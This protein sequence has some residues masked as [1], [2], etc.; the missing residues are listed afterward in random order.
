[1]TIYESVVE[2]TKDEPE[3]SFIKAA[4]EIET[5]EAER[6]AVDHASKPS[7]TGNSTS[8]SC[9][10]LPLVGQVRRLIIHRIQ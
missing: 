1:M 3:I 6:V 5:G 4:Y 9:E 10:Y 2:L 7:T 8:S